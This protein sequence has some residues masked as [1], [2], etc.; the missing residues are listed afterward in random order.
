MPPG[1]SWIDEPNLA[2]MAYPDSPEDVA[3]L[4]TQGIEVLVSLTETPAPRGWVNEAGLMLVHVPIPDMT[5]PDLKQFDQVLDAVEQANAAG[6]GV[7]IHCAAGRGRT[8]TVVAAYFVR[9]GLSAV[10]A[11][12]KTRMLRPGSI[13]T[14]AQELAIINYA[15]R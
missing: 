8:G 5:A 9:D 6:L 11:I 15:R 14:D 13:E 2:A 7:V 12:Q 3:W 1:F 10:Q 4:R